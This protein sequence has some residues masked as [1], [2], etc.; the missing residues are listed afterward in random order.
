MLA[1]LWP[2]ERK[3][4]I[5]GLPKVEIIQTVWL[6]GLAL[7]PSVMPFKRKHVFRKKKTLQLRDKFVKQPTEF[8][9]T[10]LAYVWGQVAIGGSATKFSAMPLLA[11]KPKYETFA[12]AA[13]RASPAPLLLDA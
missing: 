9:P 5:K 8:S 3:V 4:V 2:W 6:V 1:N 11:M 7:W 13:K 10:M 12:G